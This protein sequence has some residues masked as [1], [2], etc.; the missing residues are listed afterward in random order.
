MK[1]FIYG[2]EQLETI[3]VDTLKVATFI[4]LI[5]RYGYCDMNGDFYAFSSAEISTG[6]IINVWL[7]K[8]N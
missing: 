5:K 1:V 4:W 6:G 3:E 8:E 2:E 7:A